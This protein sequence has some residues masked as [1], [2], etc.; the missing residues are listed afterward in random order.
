MVATPL[1][2]RLCSRDYKGAG[3]VYHPKTSL[4]Q[5][6]QMMISAKQSSFSTLKR[7]S[8]LNVSWLLIP[9]LTWP[10]LNDSHRGLQLILSENLSITNLFLHVLTRFWDS[11]IASTHTVVILYI[12]MVRSQLFCCT[13]VWHPHLMKEICHATKY[14]L[15]DYTCSYKTHLIKLRILPLMCLFELQ[16]LLFAIKSVDYINFSS[17]NT[18]SGASNKLVSLNNTSILLLSLANPLECHAHY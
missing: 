7:L 4:N 6:S 1:V 14:L 12:W 17:A 13:Q 16:D 15:N 8:T 3:V 18:R 11:Y 9:F 5:F 2:R 10:Y